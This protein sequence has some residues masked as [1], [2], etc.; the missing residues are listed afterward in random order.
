M[1]KVFF[2][3]VL[4]LFIAFQLIVDRYL[5]SLIHQ[6]NGDTVKT[7]IMDAARGMNKDA[8]IDGPTGKIYLPE[9]HLVLPAYPQ[10]LNRGIKYHYNTAEQGVSE[11]ELTITSYR[12]LASSMT[13]LNSAS[14]I[15]QVFAHV[16]KFQACNRQID[17]TVKDMGPQLNDSYQKVATKHL[18]DGGDIYMYLDQGCK[19]NSEELIAYLQQI[20][21]Y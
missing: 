4:G 13:E 20:Q 18:N 2:A 9:A 21:S 10:A 15:E 17:I 3:I 16:P 19:E 11:K 7:L 1:A 8:V 6:G 14:T 5:L 12:S